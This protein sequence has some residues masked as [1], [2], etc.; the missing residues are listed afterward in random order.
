M[1]KIP[2]FF[3]IIFV[4][5]ACAAALF[6]GNN[7]PQNIDTTLR[8]GDTSTQNII[9]NKVATSGGSYYLNSTGQLVVGASNY[10]G[11]MTQG[12][13]DATSGY[14]AWHYGSSGVTTVGTYWDASK[15][16]LRAGRDSTGTNWS[17]ANT[18]FYSFCS[19]TNCVVS[20]A[21]SYAFG[22]AVT[23]SG[24]YSATI[25]QNLTAGSAANTVVIGQGVD[26]TTN[27]MINNTA[28]SLMIGFNSTVPTL[29]VGPSAGV[30]T[31]GNVGIG[32][33]TIPDKLTVNGSI[34][35]GTYKYPVAAA[36]AE[37][38]QHAS[39]TIGLAATVVTFPVAFSATPTVTMSPI[40]AGG[41]FDNCQP[42]IITATN[43]TAGCETATTSVHWIAIGN[44]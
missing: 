29:F 21:N 7:N 17:D 14:D 4:V 5:M 24:A 38:I 37:R 31:T 35:D 20:G 3:V 44:K 43:F 16:T 25:G 8:I 39:S 19:G 27:R 13:N 9:V 6:A 28:S 33:T 36:T 34:S 30:G 2:L 10:Y 12:V 32:T 22:N 41:N 42:S 23:S 40:Y 15:G 26:T 11:I 1:K 18:G